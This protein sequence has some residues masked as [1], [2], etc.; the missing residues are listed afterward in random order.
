[1][2]NYYKGERM[3][4]PLK[5]VYRLIKKGCWVITPNTGEIISVAP[6]DLLIDFY[7]KEV[8]LKNND[9]LNLC[10]KFPFQK[11]GVNWALTKEEL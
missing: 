7:R 8:V 1:M 3:G 10:I 6:K 11:Y 2:K 5:I 4:L 9:N